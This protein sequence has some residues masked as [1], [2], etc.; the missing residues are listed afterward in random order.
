M[1]KC[2]SVMVICNKLLI[3]RDIAASFL[4]KK[5][6]APKHVLHNL[7][8]YLSML[9]LYIA[10]HWHFCQSKHRLKKIKILCWHSVTNIFEHKIPYFRHFQ[11]GQKRG[12]NIQIQ[13]LPR[14][15]NTIFQ[16][17]VVGPMLIV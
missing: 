9:T 8:V 11:I 13:A 10:T 3:Y 16:M 4:T 15:L 17:L 5:T 14:C 1:I 2:V 6:L 7:N 12:A